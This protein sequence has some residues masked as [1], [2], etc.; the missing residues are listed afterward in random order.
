VYEAARRHGLAIPCDLSVVGFDDLTF[1]EWT[2]PPLTTI[3]QPLHEMGVAAART[4]LRLVNGERLE[5][6]RMELATR[7]IVRESTAPR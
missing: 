2:A 5:S 4:L 1:A 6:T 7:L 3:R